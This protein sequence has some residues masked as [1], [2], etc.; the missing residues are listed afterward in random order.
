MISPDK[1]RFAYMASKGGKGERAAWFRD[2]D[3]NGHGHEWRSSPDGNANRIAG[4]HQF[5]PVLDA[6]VDEL[7]RHLGQ[8]QRQESV[9]DAQV[10]VVG[11]LTA[12]MTR[13]DGTYRVVLAAGRY[14]LRV[15]RI[16][17]AAARIV[18]TFGIEP[19]VAMLSFSNFG[20]VRHPE[21]D[22]VA[23]AVALLR[24]RDPSL[25]VDGEMQADT[26]L[27][28]HKLKKTYPFSAL[29]E[30]ANVL[31]FPNLSAGNIAYKLLNHLGG[32]TA[33]SVESRCTS[34]RG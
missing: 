18:R 8:H 29:H 26:A 10:R 14:D 16:G 9:A 25:I 28:E 1:T 23:R 24:S 32:A 34:R 17:Y 27:D 19:R 21:T 15:S 13:S 12:V 3:G 6:D 4:D 31:I 2:G 5:G 7:E 22:K 20:S 11:T 30:P 33:M